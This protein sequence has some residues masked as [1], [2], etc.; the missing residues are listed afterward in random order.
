VVV[1]PWETTVATIQIE[2]VREALDK[3]MIEH[4]RKP[5]GTDDPIRK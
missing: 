2:C 5:G 1:E 3:R 4:R